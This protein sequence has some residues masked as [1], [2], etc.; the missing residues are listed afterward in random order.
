MSVV[1][2]SK[3]YQVTPA[4]LFIVLEEGNI[5]CQKQPSY[6]I[7]FFFLKRI[8]YQMIFVYPTP[9]AECLK[10]VRCKAVAGTQKSHG[11]SSSCTKFANFGYPPVPGCFGWIL[12]RHFE[13]SPSCQW[14]WH[15]CNRCTRTVKN[16]GSGLHCDVLWWNSRA[17]PFPPKLRGN[18]GKCRN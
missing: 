7:Q 2:C 4:K 8:F 9:L 15:T 1:L 14:C 6:P 11:W 5:F 18:D 17:Q 10:F 12:T 13:P 3:V 16:S